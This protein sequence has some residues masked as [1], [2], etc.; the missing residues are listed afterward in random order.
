MPH[1][2]TT[3][4]EKC[5]RN[6]CSSF[7]YFSICV[8]THPLKYLSGCFSYLT[9]RSKIHHQEVNLSEGV[10]NWESSCNCGGC[11]LCLVELGEEGISKCLVS[12]EVLLWI[13]QHSL[14]VFQLSSLQAF[15]FRFCICLA[16]FFVHG[17]KPCPARCCGIWVLITSPSELVNGSVQG[18]L[19]PVT[20]AVVSQI[21]SVLSNINAA[22]G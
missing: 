16:E 8:S 10:L 4:S 11:F 6:F 17:F 14:Y 3:A 18:H 7:W 22:F 21:H 2:G 19:F 1:R 9:E 15:S 13:V 20:Q 5:Q 12:P